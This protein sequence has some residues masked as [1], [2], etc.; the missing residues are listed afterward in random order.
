MT[1]PF[2]ATGDI[3]LT[4]D[5]RDEYRWRIFKFLR[6]MAEKHG[7]NHFVILGDLT[8]KK[9]KHSSRLVNRIVDELHALP[10][11]VVVMKGNHDYDADPDTP[12]F[13]FLGHGGGAI[14]AGLPV[15]KVSFFTTPQAF[16]IGTTPCLIIPHVRKT[17]G[18]EWPKVPAG[19]RFVF[20]HQTFH[21]AVSENGM[22]MP[23]LPPDLLTLPDGCEIVSGDIHVPQV[24]GGL[25][26]KYACNG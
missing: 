4:D 22:V 7:V 18:Y 5:P 3:H 1:T 11:R 20:T 23:G 8:D 17:D 13:R 25:I 2:L 15:S 24:L 16:N 6:R 19:T 21:G 9:D 14:T 12:F 26:I 10:G